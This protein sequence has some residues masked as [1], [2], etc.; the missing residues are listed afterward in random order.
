MSRPVATSRS[1]RER[2]T[3]AASCA[4]A[5]ERRARSAALLLERAD[6]LFDRRMRAEQ[7]DQAAAVDAECGHGLRQGR[8][9]ALPEA[10]QRAPH[11][12]RARQGRPTAVRAVL[13]P[14][15]EPG[16]DERGEQAEHGLQDHDRNEVADTAATLAI[17]TPAERAVD[18]TADH[19]RKENHEG[20]EHALKQRERHHVAVFDVR[21]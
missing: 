20:V 13:T 7:A 6:A 10:A 3:R 12:R 5:A 21:D 11:R 9:L 17:V 2:P 18:E 16:D 8:L 19:A 4:G 15:T 1:R 14:P